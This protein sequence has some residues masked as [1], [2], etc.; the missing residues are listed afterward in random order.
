MRFWT[1]IGLLLLLLHLGAKEGYTLPMDSC[2]VLY[3]DLHPSD[4]AYSEFCVNVDSVRIDTCH[5]SP[6]YNEA[7][8]KRWF[9]I[10]FTNYAINVPY[11]PHDTVI[12]V[13]WTGIDTA[14]PT[15][16]TSFSALETKHGT[17]WLKK[18]APDFT[19]STDLTSHIFLLRFDDYVCIDSV[20]ADLK[21][22]SGIESSFISYPRIADY[23]P[24]VASKHGASLLRVQPNLPN[25]ELRLQRV[26]NQPIRHVIIYDSRGSKVLDKYFNANEQ[27]VL[28]SIQSLAIGMY[29]V[30]C[31]ELLS[32]KIIIQN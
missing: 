7:F 30:T 4:S 19:D 24:E 31:D 32:V 2:M 17:L 1:L 16:R 14:Y 25:T 11:G 8:G 28:L 3:C 18:G 21:N 26:D 22:I 23:V 29:V 27:Q 9:K 15:L 5:G 10:E 20:L 13:S 12:E 6:T